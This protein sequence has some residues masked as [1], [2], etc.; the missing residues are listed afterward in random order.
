MD[1]VAILIKTI[2][3]K[4]E[5]K[6]NVEIET[7][8]TLVPVKKFPITRQEWFEAGRSG[9]RPSFMLTTSILNYDG[10]SRVEFQGK[11]YGIYRTYEDIENE[12]I[13]LYCEQKAGV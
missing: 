3:G 2:W 11:K 13:E 5:I 6:Q 9:L 4:D 10:E 1:D 12:T 8:R 7:S